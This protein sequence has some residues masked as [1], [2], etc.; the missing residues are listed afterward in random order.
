MGTNQ[1]HLYEMK[2]TPNEFR[3]KVLLTSRLMIAGEMVAIIEVF[4]RPPSESCNKRVNLLSLQQIS[5]KID[6]S[7]S[8]KTQLIHFKTM[9]L[10]DSTNHISIFN[11]SH[12]HI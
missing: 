8:I 2:T 7:T 10:D 6:N 11:K 5:R 3:P 1:N 12:F 4:V 9:L